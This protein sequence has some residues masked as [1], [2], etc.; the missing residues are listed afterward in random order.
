MSA[1]QSS[2]HFSK[3]GKGPSLLED[4]VAFRGSFGFLWPPHP[5][6]STWNPRQPLFLQG[7]CGAPGQSEGGYLSVLGLGLCKVKDRYSQP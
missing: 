2:R 1:V 4:D 6:L 5:K 3:N 7:L